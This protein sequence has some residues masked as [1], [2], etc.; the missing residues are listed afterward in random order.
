MS[1]FRAAY[2]AAFGA[3]GDDP[4]YAAVSEGGR[5]A[6]ME[7]WLPLFY[8][9]METLFDYLPDDAL[10]G[11]DHLVQLVGP[12]WGVSFKAQRL[13]WLAQLILAYVSGDAG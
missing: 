12:G 10:V 8:E 11:V 6:G 4:L 13:W 1:R 2:L 9:R 3:A 5:R 7:H